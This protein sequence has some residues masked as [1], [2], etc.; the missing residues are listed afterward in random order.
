MRYASLSHVVTMG[1]FLFAFLQVYSFSSCFEVLFSYVVQRHLLQ[2]GNES[3]KARGVW[4]EILACDDERLLRAGSVIFV[5]KEKWSLRCNLRIL[6]IYGGIHVQCKNRSRLC[7]L[8]TGEWVMIL[9]TRVAE[10]LYRIGSSPLLVS[11]LKQTF[12]KQSSCC[13]LQRWTKLEW[14]IRRSVMFR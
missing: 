9:C 7:L 4:G 8:R 2:M 11:L 3:W 1:G 12:L 13:A 5:T 10:S 14:K 6:G